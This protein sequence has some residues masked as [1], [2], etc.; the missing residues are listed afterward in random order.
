MNYAMQQGIQEVYLAGLSGGA[1]TVSMVA[2]M[3]PRVKI[4]VQVAGAMPYSMRFSASLQ[5]TGDIGDYEQLCNLPPHPFRQGARH[6]GYGFRRDAG[7][8]YCKVCNYRCGS[9]RSHAISRSKC[10]ERAEKE[11]CFKL[12]QAEASSSWP[13]WKG[14][15]CCRSSMKMTPVAMP[16]LKGA[17]EAIAGNC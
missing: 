14:G 8:E 6:I 5:P 15:S 2:A 10:L 3:D 9:V 17:L 11:P 16:R 4:A 7:R 12:F 1:W 13:R